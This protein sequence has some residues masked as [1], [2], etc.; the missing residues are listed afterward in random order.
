MATIYSTQFAAGTVTGAGSSV[1][2][3]PVGYIAVV[4]CITLMNS[5]GGA[6]VGYVSPDTAGWLASLISSTQ[7]ESETTDM[8]QVLNHGD[9]L[10]VGLVGAGT[11][12]YAISGYLLSTP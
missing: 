11:M 7:Y 12:R 1:Y 2:S 8:R 5:A 3:V 6:M 10:Y 9:G 4:R